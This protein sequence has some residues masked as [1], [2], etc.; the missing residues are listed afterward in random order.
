MRLSKVGL[1]DFVALSLSVL[2]AIGEARSL[3]ARFSKNDKNFCI[4]ANVE[5]VTTEPLEFYYAVPL[6]IVTNDCR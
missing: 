2:A 1:G 5:A 3:T 6:N 4:Y